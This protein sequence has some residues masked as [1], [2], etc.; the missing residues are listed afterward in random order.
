M[1]ES[2]KNRRKDLIARLQ[3]EKGELEKAL[4]NDLAEKLDGDHRSQY[5]ETHDTA[6]RSIA[7]LEE[8]LGI[9]LADLHKEEL[10]KAIEAERKLQN[11][12]YGICEICGTRISDQRLS[13][14]PSAIYC[15]ECAKK[16]EGGKN[17]AK[18]PKF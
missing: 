10:G 18:R 12:T 13:A 3:T 8:S 15:V 6:D 7:D 1:Q 2:V 9:R 5:I 17:H 16:L 11:G 14:L 4:H